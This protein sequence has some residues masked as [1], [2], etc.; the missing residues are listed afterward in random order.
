MYRWEAGREHQTSPALLG[1]ASHWMY[2]LPPWFLYMGTRELRTPGSA[3][4]GRRSGPEILGIG[5]RQWE[6]ATTAHTTSG[7]RISLWAPLNCD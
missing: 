5:G 4:G 3:D 6:A 7:C 2:Q 1:R